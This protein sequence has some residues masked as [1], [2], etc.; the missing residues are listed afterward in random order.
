MNRLFQEHSS[1]ACS[2]TLPVPLPNLDKWLLIKGYSGTEL[3]FFFKKSINVAPHCAVRGFFAWSLHYS[4]FSNL[5]HSTQDIKANHSVWSSKSTELLLFSLATEEKS[6]FFVTCLLVS[7]LHHESSTNPHPDSQTFLNPQQESQACDKKHYSCPHL[8]L[9]FLLLNSFFVF[10]CSLC[11]T[12]SE[13]INDICNIY[14]VH[15]LQRYDLPVLCLS[16]S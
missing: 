13:W 14:Y 10:F 6:G 16:E 2:R 3:F 12:V 1:C 9:I 8:L 7:D 4:Y 11:K 15:K 5:L